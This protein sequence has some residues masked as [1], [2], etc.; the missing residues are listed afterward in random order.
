M[1]RVFVYGTLKIG[2][3]NHAFLAGRRPPAAGSLAQRMQPFPP[4]RDLLDRRRR[5]PHN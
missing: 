4:G 3:E 5:R 1:T 2:G